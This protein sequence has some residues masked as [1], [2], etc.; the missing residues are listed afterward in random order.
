[1]KNEKGR[2]LYFQPGVGPKS[3]IEISK[4]VVWIRILR[5]AGVNERCLRGAQRLEVKTAADAR[6]SGE[7]GERVSEN[8]THCQRFPRILQEM[9]FLKMS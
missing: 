4:S 3:L 6:N 8:P 5:T 9:R 2:L 1:M 7:A